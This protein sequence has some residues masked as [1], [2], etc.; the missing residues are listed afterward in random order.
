MTDRI[1]RNLEKQ[2]KA[3]I[4]LERER[5]GLEREKLELEQSKLALEERKIAVGRLHSDRM[6]SSD[7]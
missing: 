6:F 5:M 1:S 7:Q 4:D 2:R 3:E